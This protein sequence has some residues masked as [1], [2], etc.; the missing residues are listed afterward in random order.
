MSTFQGL[1]HI[2]DYKPEDKN[3]I[4]ASFLKGLYYGFDDETGSWFRQIDKDI[5][6]QNYSKI[7]EALLQKSEVK[8]ACLP[9]DQDV[10]LGYSMLSKDFNTIHWCFVKSAWRNKGIGT[11]LVP[12]HPVYV[13]HLSATGKKLLNR[14]NNPKFNP[15]SI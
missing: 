11:S 4:M 15:W 12:T 8:V 10:I 7:A 3:F 14:I 9:E 2:R 6:M 5:F 13:S 1:Y